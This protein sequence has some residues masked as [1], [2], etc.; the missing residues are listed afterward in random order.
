[1][2]KESIISSQRIYNTK[3]AM[4]NQYRL[5]MNRLV[6]LLSMTMMMIFFSP[7]FIISTG[8][9]PQEGPSYSD[10]NLYYDWDNFESPVN[11]ESENYISYSTLTQ[12]PGT[13]CSLL[14]NIVTC[15]DPRIS[16]PDIIIRI[17]SAQELFDFSN[18]VSYYSNFSS[19]SKT[20]LLDLHY[21]LGADI[22]YSI[23]GAQAFLPVGYSFTPAGQSVPIRNVFTG[24]FD[25]QGFEI[26]NLYVTAPY[27][28][29]VYQDGGTY[30]PLSEYFSMFTINEGV[31]Q[32]IGL[33]NPT[34]VLLDF[35]PGIYKTSNLVGENLG[36]INHVYLIDD[37][38]LFYAGIRYVG[39]SSLTP[40]TAA[41]I[42]HT[43]YNLFEEAYYLSPSVIYGSY[44]YRFSHVQPVLFQNLSEGTSNNLV[45]VT[46]GYASEIDLGFTQVTIDAASSTHTAKSESNLRTG[47][48]GEEDWFDTDWNFYSADSFPI[49]M[50][51]NY[52]APGAYYEISSA[53]DLAFLYRLFSFSTTNYNSLSYRLTGNIDMGVL[54]EGTYKT[55][56]Q[57]FAGQFSGLNSSTNESYIISNLSIN[58][59]LFN[60]GGTAYYLGLFSIVTGTVENVILDNYSST[61]ENSNSFYSRTLYVGSIAGRLDSGNIDNVMVN[62]TIDLGGESIS[63]TYLG[64]LVGSGSGTIHQSSVRGTIN[65][66]SHTYNS[67]YAVNPTFYLGGIVGAADGSKLT[68][69]EVVNHANITGVSA[70]GF[71]TSLNPFYTKIGGIIGY[72]YNGSAN[73]H[74]L[75]KSTNNGSL[76]AGI[77][78]GLSP[79]SYSFIGGIFGEL[80]GVAPI[81]SNGSTLVFGLLLNNGQINANYPTNT[82]TVKA[83]GIGISNT[84]AAVEYWQISNRGGFNF[85]NDSAAYEASPKMR[86][87]ATIYPI[88]AQNVTLTR[89]YNYADFSYKSNYLSNISPFFFTEQDIVTTMNY[90]ENQGNITV[91]G[92]SLTAETSIAAITTNIKVNY[93]NVVNSGNITVHTIDTSTTTSRMLFI[94]GITKTLYANGT[95]KYVLE[96]G[97][98]YG[99]II[100]ANISGTANIY[101]AGL[102]NTNISG[103]LN[104]NA[105][106]PTA[107]K[108]VINSINY[109]SISTTL[110]STNFAVDGTSNT[111][112]GG[113]VTL[114]GGSVQ[115]SVNMGNITGF[116]SRTQ[117]QSSL[118]ASTDGYYAAIITSYNSGMVIGGVV[119]VTLNGNAR[120]FDTSNSGNIIAAAPQYARAGGVL[121]VCLREEAAAGSVVT[122]YLQTS[123]ESSVS[124]YHIKNSILSNGL[125]FGDV[126]S[127]TSTRGAYGT[128]NYDANIDIVRTNGVIRQWTT[129]DTTAVRTKNGTEQRPVI[130]ASAGGVIGYGL[131]IMRRMLNHGTIWSTD[132]AGG[133]IG[134]TYVLGGDSD[135]VT[136]VDINTAINYGDI[137]PVNTNKYVD[138]DDYTLNIELVASCLMDD[139]T[140]AL[141]LTPVKRTGD[142]FSIREYPEDKRGYGGIIG[143]L[144]RG[145]NGILALTITVGSTTYEGS[146]DYII[147]ANP[148]IDLIGRLDQVYTFSYSSGTYQFQGAIYYSAKEND[149][150]PVTFTGFTFYG[151]EV[152]NVSYVK[153]GKTYTWTRTIT[154]YKYAQ[155]GSVYNRVDLTSYG[156]RTTSTTN[157]TGVIPTGYAIGTL[158]DDNL[159]YNTGIVVPRI[160]ET[161][162]SGALNIYSE[163]F[164]NSLPTDFTEYIYYAENKLLADR[165]RLESK[166]QYRA[167]G[168]YVLATSAGRQ[169]GSVLPANISMN[170]LRPEYE[171]Q[172]EI[173]ISEYIEGTTNRAIELYNASNSVVD[174]ANY[175]LHLYQDGATVPSYSYQ[176]SG[177]LGIGKTYVLGANLGGSTNTAIQAAASS[178]G[179]LLADPSVLSFSGNDALVL[180]KGTDVIDSIGKVGENPQNGYWGNGSTGSTANFTMVRKAKI[181]LGDFNSSDSYDP[182]VEWDFFATDTFDY[183]GSHTNSYKSIELGYSALRQT[184]F[185][186]KSDLIAD[187]FLL[188]L[189]EN[190]GSFT[191]LTNGS[192]VGNVITFN[193]SLIAFSQT[194]AS[195]Y[196]SEALIS[197]YALIAR[198]KGGSETLTDFQ[199]DISA[200]AI[201]YGIATGDDIAVL[202]VTVPS[203][204]S[205][206]SLGFFGV[207]SEAFV[208]D[209][210]FAAATNASDYY[211][212]YEIQI[213][214]TP[215]ITNYNGT[216]INTVTFNGTNTYTNTTVY[217][218]S[219]FETDFRTP[220]SG[221]SVS[222]F[223][224]ITFN[225][226]DNNNVMETGYDFK[227]NFKLYYDV[228]DDPTDMLVSSLYYSVSSTAMNSSNQYQITFTFDQTQIRG[229]TYYFVYSYFPSSQPYTV[230]FSRNYSNTATI[231]NLNYYLSNGTWSTSPTI[232]MGEKFDISEILP[233]L[234]NFVPSA[235]YYPT[236]TFAITHIYTNYAGASPY[237]GSITFSPFSTITQI[238]QNVSYVAGKKQIVITY[239]IRSEDN[240]LHEG[241][242]KTI[243]E[244]DIDLAKVYINNNQVLLTDVKATREAETTRFSIDLGLNST[245]HIYNHSSG[246]YPYFSIM[247][248]A[249]D[250]NITTI[251]GFSI[252]SSSDYLFI[253]V[254]S[255]VLPGTY[256]VYF[257]LNRTP[258]DVYELPTRLTIVKSAGTDAYLKDISFSSSAVT[259]SSYPN[260]YIANADGS[261]KIPQGYAPGIYFSGIDYNGSNTAETPVTNYRIVGYVSRIPLY[262]FLPTM[263][264]N[265]PIG[266]SIQRLYYY[267][268]GSVWRYSPAIT[269]ANVDSEVNDSA[270]GVSMTG[271]EWLSGDFVN[272]YGDQTYIDDSIVVTYRVTSES[273]TKTVDYHISVVDQDYNVSMSFSVYYCSLTSI[274]N[275][276]CSTLASQD[277][278]G[279]QNQLIAI[280]VK[281]YRLVDASDQ[282]VYLG[283]TV[284]NDPDLY[285]KYNVDF[286]GFHPTDPLITEAAQYVYTANVPHQYSFGRN[287]SGFY[288]IDVELPL[289]ADRNEKYGYVIRFVDSSDIVRELPDFGMGLQGKYFF[290]NS[291]TRNR[292][293]VFDVYIYQ[294]ENPTDTKWGLFDY[295]KFWE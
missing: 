204:A 128:S 36:N 218:S 46:P 220:V 228:S 45:Y 21:V 207:Y 171:D 164:I 237:S 290:I 202:N 19:A 269:A 160:S 135:P 78:T 226:I 70:N 167:N 94:S 85:N 52:N 221:Y 97:I 201:K 15:A 47:P 181:G 223:G 84:T 108:G 28:S 259:E 73:I 29:L 75:I 63:K 11:L 283:T 199:A 2:R 252:S 111:F 256:V 169:Y 4:K 262:S 173:V 5:H 280:S 44:S 80:G 190:Q 234:I 129:I 151:E 104:E 10:L 120:V 148:R 236:N 243:T 203:V 93:H 114:N 35:I 74:S 168:M 25:G 57:T 197:E 76:T 162:V 272:L 133:I 292:S 9:V 276:T 69:D 137:E 117:A 33:L 40:L 88:S 145:N 24:V 258:T 156:T 7:F 32:N 79:A 13:Y 82:S 244:T 245:L 96:N 23:M 279:F 230:F 48:I 59:G 102:V 191:T 149:Q 124:S 187:D 186:D 127:I 165:F 287:V 235:N 193:I 134:A 8:A 71:S 247:N 27:S 38:E 195:Y 209:P 1:M 208:S 20:I 91:S 89:A 210:A 62:G 83:A 253:D 289:G 132:V 153:N 177:L 240:V 175:S 261:I 200:D 39:G 192:L 125:N 18:D 43:N 146:F 170:Q 233:T 285:P 231:E 139:S 184:R 239:S 172:S 185:N 103:D 215:G 155:T 246:T 58:H 270:I 112:V 56:T 248:D 241:L 238:S 158:I 266:A 34:L 294:I 293:V 163:S 205:T 227:D 224:S 42:V 65:G 101:V 41:G 278:S 68:L 107:T 106:I 229:G 72:I 144:Q 166:P 12:T 54:A 273:G 219:T 26:K 265:L 49:L 275:G 142:V 225:F 254:S 50:G 64:G 178:S 152:S 60:S 6:L 180:K 55:P 98:N 274:Q 123:G 136:L 31:I 176:L 61:V 183:I 90:V 105:S 138:L 126:A 159:A 154:K 22:D 174:M 232:A 188:T 242:T 277:G 115:D 291:S 213:N 87:V 17:D 194:S 130:N 14:S 150:T 92:F 16:N 211:T 140:R 51:L 282:E 122:T 286:F 95:E 196:I 264:S 255:A 222:T 257:L 284:I 81:L 250:L 109:G 260:I 217:T 263:V 77:I 216:K 141:Y 37:R 214:F 281:N 249:D 157:T 99:N 198:K 100:F 267:E 288:V 86:F 295:F 110:S 53:I 268:T 161:T 147:N 179:V 131:S 271:S 3:Y 116:N 67:S 113:I 66:N 118:S 119:G 182:S 251:S 212:E 189:V 121:G 30:I 143:R 206:V